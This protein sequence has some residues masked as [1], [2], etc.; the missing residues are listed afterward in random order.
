MPPADRLSPSILAA[1]GL[2]ACTGAT[3]GGDTGKDSPYYSP[4]LTSPVDTYADTD[5]DSDSDS[6][7]DTDTGT[8]ETGGSGTI[9]GPCLSPTYDTGG[10]TADT[11]TVGTDTG[12]SDDPPP[13]PSS[14][15]ILGRLK[16]GQVLPSDVL[17]RIER[18]SR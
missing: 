1:L 12:A 15:A 5:T 4:C 6:D 10:S 13:N 2:A 17:E 9:I 18:K 14:A 8:T 16:V 7:A 11:G 3:P